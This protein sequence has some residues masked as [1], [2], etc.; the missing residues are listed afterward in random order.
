M[1]STID[2]TEVVA[3]DARGRVRVSRERRAA[4]LEQFD[5]SGMSAARFAEWCGVKYP[6][7]V[8]WLQRRRRPGGQ[9]APD[10]A[11]PTGGGKVRWL[12]AVIGAGAQGAPG[13]DPGT[14]VIHLPGGASLGVR[15][16]LSAR[17]AARVLAALAR[18]GAG[19]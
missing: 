9:P 4:V 5:A 12:E 17:L 7:L 10:A 14:L 2:P 11:P 19:C 15:D 1:T 3:Q 8:G 6:T 16:E 13:S 18:E